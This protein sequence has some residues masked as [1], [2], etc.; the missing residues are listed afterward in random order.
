[1]TVSAL[2]VLPTPSVSMHSIYPLP[3]TESALGPCRGGEGEGGRGLRYLPSAVYLGIVGVLI[4]PQRDNVS[5]PSIYLL[6]SVY[7]E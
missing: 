6:P 2:G 7:L 3:S 1:M 4:G 5:R